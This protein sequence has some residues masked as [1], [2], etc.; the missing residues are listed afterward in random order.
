LFCFSL[1]EDELGRPVS[2]G[3]VFIKTHTKPDG[4]Y[5]DQKAEQIATSYKKNVQLRQAELEA[6]TSAI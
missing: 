2:V 1:Q 4:T 6:D 5:V 3:E